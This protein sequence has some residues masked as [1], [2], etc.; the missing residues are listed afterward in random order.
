MGPKGDAGIAGPM[1]PK[2]D[3]G[4]IGQKGDAGAAGPAGPKGENGIGF[5]TITG[6]TN[7]NNILTAN[8]NNSAIGNENLTYYA[9]SNTLATGKLIL[10]SLDSK[11]SKDDFN[12][13]RYLVADANGNIGY[14]KGGNY[15]GMEYRDTI[16][17]NFTSNG[18]M[19]ILLNNTMTTYAVFIQPPSS[20]IKVFFIGSNFTGSDNNTIELHCIDFTNTSSNDNNLNNGGNMLGV[21]SPISGNNTIKIETKDMISDASYN[22]TGF[23]RL[24]GIRARSTGTTNNIYLL[25]IMIGL[26]I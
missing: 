8:G 24:L 26:G 10:K 25:N 20:S 7:R 13:N 15:T 18:N 6:H 4:P 14:N 3:A 19:G 23:P 12:Y 16:L 11:N 5:N 22:K 9:E 1:G 2:G 17:F 21:I